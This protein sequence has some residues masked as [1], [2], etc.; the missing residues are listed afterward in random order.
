[1][2]KSKGK[3]VRRPWPAVDLRILREDYAD[4]PTTTLATLFGRPINQVYAMANS[5]GL[6]KSAEYMKSEAACRLRRGDNVG[7]AHRFP[8]GHVPANKGRKSPGL[9][10]GRMGE[11]QFKKGSRPHT[12][13]PVGTYRINSDGVLELKT[14]DEPG[15]YYVRW[16]PVH[17]LVWEQAHG[18]IPKGHMVAFK[19]GRKTTDRELI[20]LDALELITQRENMLRNTVHNLPKPLVHVVQLRAAINRQINKRSKDTT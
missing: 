6:A 1:V 11:T 12:W 13:L 20:T 16:K 18:A 14:N 3:Q 7:S 15:P 5:L 10:I 9:A 4:T 17:R 8:K 2:T 19:P